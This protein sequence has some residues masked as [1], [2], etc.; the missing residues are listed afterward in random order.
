ME[1][2]TPTAS[3]KKSIELFEVENA[4]K[5]HQLKEEFFAAYESFKPVNL[6]K[7]TL[8]DI[9]SSPYL[10]DNI[11]GNV[12]GLA[13]GYFSKRLVI[14]ASV[15]GFRK[16]IGAVLQFG[17]TNIVARHTDKISSFGRNIFQHIFRKKER[18][19]SSSA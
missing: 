6:F 17:V 7:N 14:G 5:L 18:I 4:A 9:S 13:T 10:I 3:L 16:L 15:N 8:N 11:V 19:S 12:L 1:N 2:M